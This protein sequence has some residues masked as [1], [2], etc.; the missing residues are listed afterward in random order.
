MKKFTIKDYK[1]DVH[2]DW[3]PGCLAPD[4]LIAMADGTWKPIPDVAVGDRVVG[5]DGK[6]HR[7][8]ETMSHWHPDVMHRVTV[9]CF[10]SATLTP[11]HPM[12]VVRRQRRKRVNSEWNAEWVPADQVH[13]GDYVAFPRVAAS[14]DVASLP[15]AYERKA[16]DTRSKPLPG[17]IA[18]DENALRLMGLYIAEGHSHHRELVWTFGSHEHD[19]VEETVRLVGRTL[20]LH[21]SVRERSDKGS[22]EVHVNSSYLAEIFASWFGAS[23][24]TKVVPSVL[25]SLSP[26]RQRA[27]IG[28]LW[29]GDGWTSDNKAHFKTISRVL[30]Q[31]MKTLLVR[32]GM[33]PTVS[34]Q[35]AKDIHL[36]AYAVEVVSTRDYNVLAGI[37][38]T[39]ERPLPSTKAKPPMVITDDYVFLPV[40]KNDVVAYEGYVHNFEVED[41]HSYVSSLGALHNCGDFGILSGI[42]LALQQMNLDPDK[43]A[44]FSGIGCSGKTPHYIKAY[45]FHTLHGRVLP[46]ATG[47]R[48]ANSGVTVIALGGDGDG[49]GI[50]AGYFVNSGRRNVDMAYLV[51][52]NS[53]YGLTKGQA[54]PTLRK[55]ERTK[56]MP[57]EAIQDGI[58]PIA[59]AVAAGYTFIARGYALE[60]KHLA[61]II[62]KA[63]EHKGAALVDVLQTCPTYNDLYTKEWYEGADLP[64]KRSRLYR[65]DETDFDGVVH[66]VTDEKEIV[67]K[68]AAA[69]VKSY[70][71]EPIPIGV[72]YQAELPTYEDALRQRIPA[73]A[74]KPLVDI[75]VF[76]RDVN[77]L[78]EAMR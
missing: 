57:E 6:P 47:A 65:L 13:I 52:N 14:E 38:G 32:Q 62:V 72:Y 36:E 28:G 44:V 48:L 16:K 25:M 51:H 75:D 42:Q 54:S 17:A 71:R 37:V 24:E 19:L 18:L 41:V 4:T 55:G 59:M 46:V 58:N 27:L 56:S 73:L 26:A 22:T 1:S 20:E 35:R 61:G 21:A 9:K 11:D 34:V 8:T 5:H 76:H 64:E 49:Y 40:R 3:C 60:P 63:I 45:G 15:L 23:A 67:A 78:L 77:A 68:K 53:V 30:A 29:A 12:Y 31:Q 74:E 66:D 69:V 2:N 50:G 7:V 39:R 43:V 70:E 33:V 10:G